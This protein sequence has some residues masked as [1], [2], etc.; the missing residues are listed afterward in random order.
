MTSLSPLLSARIARHHGIVTRD[1]L[2]GDGLT[3]NEIRGLVRSR[4]I[5]RM[6]SSVYRLMTS[7]ET[8][9]ASCTAASLADE[10]AVITGLSAARLWA[11][12]HTPVLSVP[13][14]LV[15]HDRTPLAAGI[16][17]RRTNVLEA[18][19]FVERP[20]GIRVASPPR[21]WFD[22]AI[23]LP[24]DRFEK[25][26]EW[27]LD[28][29][30]NVPAL[31]RMTRRLSSRGRPGLARVRRVL[32]QREGWQ[33]PAGSGLEVD[34]FN[35]LRE[36]GVGP[37]VRQ[38]PLKLFNGVIIHPDVAVPPAKWAIEVDHVTWHGGRL[39]AQRDKA[40]D[41]QARRIG[42]QVDRVTDQEL[43]DDFI[44]TIRE[45]VDLYQLR[46]EEVAA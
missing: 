23:Y 37:L 30:V 35:A 33:R 2:I 20:D 19:D 27:V 29:H 40:R 7:P 9:E 18:E 6:H 38:H 36:R 22:C 10:E 32:S 46:L 39:D 24:D 12:R 42:W 14:V 26:T 25:L 44:G 41:R 1:E 11:F 16:Q 21:A 8:F 13:Q 17:L 31:W 4:T 5:V 3:T 28:R 45:L 15:R 34:V 43:R